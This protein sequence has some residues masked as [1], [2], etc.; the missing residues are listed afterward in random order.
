MN[1]QEREEF[2]NM[3]VH[4]YQG[5]LFADYTNAAVTGWVRA[6]E[7]EGEY[8]KLAKKLDEAQTTFSVQDPFIT[9]MVRK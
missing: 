1:P 9:A 5:A 7:D 4:T 3:Q 8:D 6:Y 2:W